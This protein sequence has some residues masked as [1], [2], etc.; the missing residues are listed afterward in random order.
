[1]QLNDLRKEHPTR[2]EMELGLDGVHRRVD[3]LH[4]VVH[5]ERPERRG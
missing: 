4:A 5:G 2:H 1:M 3:D